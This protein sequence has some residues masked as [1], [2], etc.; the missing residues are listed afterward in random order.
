VSARARRREIVGE[1][2]RPARSP[3][4]AGGRRYLEKEAGGRSR[5]RPAGGQRSRNG[6]VRPRRS[7]G[8]SSSST[9]GLPLDGEED[10]FDFRYRDLSCKESNIERD[11][12]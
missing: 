9:A 3:M 4:R 10:D 7:G 12:C 2:G 11:F 5:G 8:S 1:L 6:D